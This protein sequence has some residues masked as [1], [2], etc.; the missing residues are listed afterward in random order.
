MWQLL[1]PCVEDKIQREFFIQKTVFYVVSS[2]F[3][4]QERKGIPVTQK[5]RLSQAQ[6]QTFALIYLHK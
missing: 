5:G 4:R 3:K 6:K 1:L 2:T